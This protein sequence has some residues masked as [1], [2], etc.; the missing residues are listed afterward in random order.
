MSSYRWIPWAFAGA[1]SV[2]IAV[3]GALAYFAASSSTGLV[4]EH[5]FE[6]GNSYNRVL[7]AAAAQDRLGWRGSLRVIA[8]DAGRAE[9]AVQLSDRAGKPLTAAS[10]TARLIRPVEPLPDLV[11]PLEETRAGRYENAAVLSRR[12]QWEVRVAA[13]RGEELFQFAQRIVVK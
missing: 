2:V 6:S 10:V 1:L 9:I 12:G 4:S 5:P 3:N 8:N 11:L 13:R 7:D